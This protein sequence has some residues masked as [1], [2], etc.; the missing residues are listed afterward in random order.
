ML[1][2]GNA[3]NERGTFINVAHALLKPTK[4]YPEIQPLFCSPLFV[5]ALF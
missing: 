3:A 4:I 2:L 5:L 1:F